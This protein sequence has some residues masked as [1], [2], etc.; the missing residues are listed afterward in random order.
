MV[1]PDSRTGQ[2]NN[3]KSDN[4][5]HVFAQKF[6]VNLPI[7]LFLIIQLIYAHKIFLFE[8]ESESLSIVSNLTS[9]DNHCDN[10]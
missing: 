3:D 6:I 2:K 10:D 9:T 8:V 4:T 1:F 5:Q 7:A